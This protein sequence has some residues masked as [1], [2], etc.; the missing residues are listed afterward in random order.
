MPVA[1]LR[2][3]VGFVLSCFYTFRVR[4]VEHG[5]ANSLYP[6][7]LQDFPRLTG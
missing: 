7:R 3:R 5:T 2:L 4:F 6:N 1:G